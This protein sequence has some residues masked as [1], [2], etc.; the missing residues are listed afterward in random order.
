MTRTFGPRERAVVVA[1]IGNNHEG[2]AGVALELVHRAADA[3]VDAVKFQTYRTELF[4]RPADTARAERLRRYQLSP[5][6]FARLAEAAHAKGLLFVSTPLDL[7]SVAVLQPL[8]DAFKIASGDITFAPLLER[9]AHTGRPVVLSSG[10]STLDEIKQ[11]MA[12]L[13]RAWAARAASPELTV[14]HCVSC[15]PAPDDQASLA[16]IPFLRGE[17]GVPVGYSDHTLGIDAAVYA[18]VLGASL[19]EKH[20]TLD[21]RYSDFRDHQL[22]ADPDE[23]KTLVG[24]VH[25]VARLLGSAGKSLQACEGPMRDAI[26]RSIVAAA[27]LPAGHVLGAADLVWMRPATGGVAPGGESQFIGRRLR[28]DLRRG[29]S[30]TVGDA[31]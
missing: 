2:D 18:A 20:F 11:A 19:I 21:K 24:R 10:A 5:D 22:S 14:L 25:H 16:A 31:D 27:D 28:R 7:D 29:D 1:E 4:V 3:G 23:M 17:L 12:T 9:V 26:R 6:D 30:V 8:V 15:Y 13:R